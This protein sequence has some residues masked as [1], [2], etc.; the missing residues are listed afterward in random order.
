MSVK[1]KLQ[2][3]KLKNALI[4]IIEILI[5][6]GIIF[7]VLM[8]FQGKVNKEAEK[9][10]G[11]SGK[12]IEN[13][14]KKADVESLDDYYIQINKKLNALIVYRYSKDR[15]TKT[16]YKSFRC[17]VGRDLKKGK[18][19]TSKTYSWL[20]INGNWH[21]NN[22][23][24]GDGS[25][26]QSAGYNNKYSYTL[27]KSSYNA[28]GKKK[29][30]GACVLLS[31][32]D[33][34]WIYENCKTGTEVSVVNGQK[35]DKLQVPFEEFTKAQKYCGWD[36]TDTES[37]NPYMKIKNG[38]LV[39]G[40]GTVYVERGYKPNYLGNILLYDEN[41]KNKTG[42]VKY[43]KINTDETGDIKVTFKYKLSSKK[44]LKLTQ[45]FKVID[46]IPPKVSCSKDSFVYEVA[47]KDKKDMNSESNI[48]D[49]T[50][51]VK[52]C[53][54]TNESGS[55]I[56]VY[57]VNKDE[58]DEGEFPVVIKA[59]DLAGNV[60]SYQVMVKIVLR[61][62]GSN[63]KYTPPKDL[64]KIRKQK[65]GL[66]ETTKKPE[67]KKKKEKTTKAVSQDETEE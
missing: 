42:L 33:S 18:Y 24:F 41:G 51:M 39:S 65:A 54:S 31:A 5:V 20:D 16:A 8:Y 23:M 36:P 60:G 28:I 32:G 35:G 45:K 57:T 2:N 48:T 40:S 11:L 9:A 19:K 38:E 21:K 26:I 63:K 56:T 6:S 25:W 3:K 46:T 10:G 58:L 53:A 67:K 62:S 47:S 27:N 55:K 7:G 12:G 64:E 30:Y 50:N 17:S 44:T 43:N 37:D 66:E 49:I 14:T 61:D 4:M 13:E 52:A 1:H 29:S 59:Q 15:K 34:D 22:T